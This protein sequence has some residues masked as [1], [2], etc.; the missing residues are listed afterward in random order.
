MKLKITMILLS[1]LMLC[2]CENGTKSSL[3]VSR[4][5]SEMTV[6]S[7]VTTSPMSATTTLNDVLTSEEVAKEIVVPTSFTENEEWLHGFIELNFEDAY[8]F[9]WLENMGSDGDAEVCIAG[10]DHIEIYGRVNDTGSFANAEKYR[11]SLSEYYS[12]DIVDIFM[13]NVT[14][15]KKVDETHERYYNIEGIDGRIY[16]EIVDEQKHDESTEPVTRLTKY[17]EIDG[18]MYKDTGESTHGTQGVF[19]YSKIV[20]MTDD[21]IIFTYPLRQDYT[22]ELVLIS[23]AEGRLV[24]ENEKWKFGWHLSYDNFTDA[25]NDI[26]YGS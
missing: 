18:V 20:R 17:I 15:V 25:Y 3:M 8:R 16:V 13:D 21:E 7:I 4:N 22:D 24:K 6:T 19:E 10:D 9:A 23:I 1:C 11:E 14:I 12:A 5:E 2:S 26:W